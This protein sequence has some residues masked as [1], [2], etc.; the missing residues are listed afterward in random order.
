MSNLATVSVNPGTE[1]INLATLAGITFTVATT[2]TL[3]ID[4]DVLICE[5]GSKPTELS[6]FHINTL[7]PFEF[8]A[9]SD[10]LWV[11]NLREYETAIIN[12]AD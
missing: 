3:Q 7:E 1:Y 8:V 5:K 11:R 2:Y 12:I 6:G 9:G 10:G 4:G